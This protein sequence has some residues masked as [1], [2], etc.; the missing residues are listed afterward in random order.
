[1][2]YH[3]LSSDIIQKSRLFFGLVKAQITKKPVPLIT[4][5]F[6][7]DKCNA[8]CTYCYADINKNPSREFSLKEWI[9]LIDDLYDR[10]TR[11]FSLVGGEPFLYPDVDRLVEY[12]VSKNVFLNL[13]T[14]GFLMHKHLAAAK[15]ATQVSISLDGD[16]SSHNKNRGEHNFEQV[17][18][19]I[20]LAVKNG[21]KVRLCTVVTRNNF[22]QIDFLL[23]FCKKHSLFI[24]FSPLVDPAESRKE[25]ALGLWL[26]DS[27]IREFFLKLKK[28]KTKSPYII[29]S[30]FNI[31]YMINYPVPYG[32]IIWK[33][34]QHSNYYSRPCTYGRF[35]YYITNIGEIYPCPV[36]WT[37]DCF[38][39]KNIFDVG[40]DET[41]RHASDLKCHCCSFA[42]AVDWDNVT[43]LPWLWYGLKM[44]MREFV[45]KR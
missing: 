24:I 15:M 28:A 38:Q 32:S 22:D 20:E 14:N 45:R 8:R 17:I 19:G 25:N 13:A 18:R 16:L 37:N 12:I 23:D 39:S 30:Y 35:L 10:G 36:M 5:L 6:I 3:S 21:A 9:K 1:M 29:N 2:K 33:N 40:L 34:G 42:N 41:L 27:M 43:T 4:H 31:E 11:F 44:T 7:T 26:S